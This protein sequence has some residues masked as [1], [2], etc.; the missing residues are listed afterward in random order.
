MIPSSVEGIWSSF[1]AAIGKD[2]SADFYEPF[3]FYDNEKGASEL[4]PN[5]VVAVAANCVIGKNRQCG[6]HAFAA[7]PAEVFSNVSD[8]LNVRARLSLKLC[9]D[10]H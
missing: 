8:N 9:L 10:E 2:R 5:V 7:R 6:A 1:T 3:Y 4:A